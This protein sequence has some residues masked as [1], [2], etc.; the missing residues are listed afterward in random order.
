MATKKAEEVTGWVGWIYFAGLM[1]ALVGGL[2]VISGLVALFSQDFFVVAEN[3]LILLDY[4][5]WGWVN[6]VIG[7]A[8]FATGTALIAGQ[9]WARAAALV[10]VVIS[11]LSNLSFMNAYPLWG[12]IALIVDGL[13]IYALVA[14]GEE[15]SQQ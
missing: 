10:L 6:L 4:A 14:H 9:A 5:A 11:A 7:L 3:R 12:I 13:V 1:L 8:V 2:Q 15:V